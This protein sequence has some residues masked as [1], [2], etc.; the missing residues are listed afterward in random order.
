[1]AFSFRKKKVQDPGFWAG[2]KKPISAS[3]PMAGVTDAAF[4]WILAR[5]GKPDVIWTE[6]ISLAGIKAKGISYFENGMISSE[7]ER[8]T[9][10]QFFGSSP[11]EFSICGKVA[12]EKSFDGIDI[13]MGC[14]DRSVEKQGSGAC[15]IKD[16]LLAKE[17]IAAAK[18]GA[19]GLPVSVKTRLGYSNV[20]E[21]EKW[22]TAIAEEAP[23][24]ITIHGRTRAQIRKGGV[25][26]KGIK[27][28]GKIIKSIS[29]GTIVLGNGDITTKEEGEG[30]ASEAK[31]D[32]YMVGRCLIGN[33]WFFIGKEA[34][35]RER[36]FV[37]KEHVEAFE[38]TFT[39]ADNFDLIKKHM[40]GY[41]S[42]FD[43][44]KDIRIKLMEAKNTEGVKAALNYFTEEMFPVI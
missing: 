37:A 35:S 6:M 12:R 26:W 15:L 3:A 44:A 42:G 30:L 22:M 28:A 33:P 40:A 32:G 5:Y 8:P 31:I 7:R 21:M 2:L 4:R 25:D 39:G 11:E 17:I 13:N 29:P 14:P 20:L 34:S 16:P 10:V 38:R 23:A 18:E 27:E 24:A 43:R 1:M 36:L 9:V 41:M 19:N